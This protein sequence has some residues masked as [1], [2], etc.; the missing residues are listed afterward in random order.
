MV[1]RTLAL[2]VAWLMT[3]STPNFAQ[4]LQENPDS[5]LTVEQWQQRVQEARR[6]SEE[7]VANARTN[8]PDPLDSAKE[9]AEVAD[10]RAMND[11]SLQRGDMVAT[12]KGLLVFIGRDLDRRQPEDFLPAPRPRLRPCET[13]PARALTHCDRRSAIGVPDDHSTLKW[14]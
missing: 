10:Q 4:E 14:E 12:S 8:P 6:R 3:A 5:E 1:P 9:D 2:L 13:D 11:P 7:F